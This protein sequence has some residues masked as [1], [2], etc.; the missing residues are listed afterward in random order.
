MHLLKQV[1]WGMI[2]CGNVTEKKSGP[3]F[4]KIENSRMLAVMSRTAE[5]VEDYARRHSIPRW[6]TRADDLINDPEVNAI[7]VATPP[8]SH[9]H[10]TSQVA[11]AGKAVYV[12]KPMAR[13]QQECQEM[14]RIC[15]EAGVPLFV[16]Y[17]RRRL[18]KFLK[19]KELLDSGL[20]GQVRAVTI[21][22]LLP[23]RPEDLKKDALPWRV[24][25]EIAGG[26]YFVDLAS[27]QLDLLDYLLG[28]IAEA[29]GHK[30][31]QAG[32]Y[33]AEDAVSAR[34][35]FQNGIL[36]SGLWC[37]TVSTSNQLDRMEII[38]SSGTLSFSCFDPSA[39]KLLTEQQVQEFVLPWPEHVQQPLLQT[40]V[41]TLRGQGD[42]PST[43]ESGVRTTAVIDE[44]LLKMNSLLR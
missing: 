41:D 28:P 29:S 21:S 38:G 37:F 11:K 44:I 33:P 18:P 14:I 32:W 9:L 6:Y 25:P 26:G 13:N 35:R 12:E 39:V 3:A 4:S 15:Q 20:I 2:G 17:Y 40:V 43:G 30:V 8:D 24:I 42:C 27:H 22:L 7:Y 5:R 1:L 31:N 10:Y 19:V 23:P 34:F 36:G 16:A